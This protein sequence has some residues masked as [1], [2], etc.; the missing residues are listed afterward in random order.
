[1]TVLLH[2][3]KSGFLKVDGLECLDKL[4]PI[5]LQRPVFIDLGLIASHLPTSPVHRIHLIHQL[6]VSL[7]DIRSGCA[8]F[9]Y[10]LLAGSMHRMSIQEVVK[11]NQVIRRPVEN[12]VIYSVSA[13]DTRAVIAVITGVRYQMRSSHMLLIT[14]KIF[15]LFPLL[16]KVEQNPILYIFGST[17]IK[18]GLYRFAP[19]LKKWI[20]ISFCSTFSKVDKVDIKL[21]KETTTCICKDKFTN[22]IFT[23]TTRCI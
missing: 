15:I 13:T 12:D 10:N 22:G 1:M 5:L 20:F 14:D 4:R 18:G 3:F 7:D 2:F 17:F 16:I 8:D 9:I 11:P 21:I 6:V 19:L 23:R